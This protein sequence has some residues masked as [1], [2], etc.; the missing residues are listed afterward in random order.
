MHLLDPAV[1]CQR[2]MHSAG[3]NSL[4]HVSKTKDSVFIDEVFGN[5][6]MTR[7]G[8]SHVFKSKCKCVIKIDNRGK[9]YLK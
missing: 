2:L 1:P 7:K 6:S 4:R 8:Y 5:Q 3:P 9:K